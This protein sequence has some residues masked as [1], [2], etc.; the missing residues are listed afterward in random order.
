[1]FRLDLENLNKAL[2]HKICLR[3]RSDVKHAIAAPHQLS[4]LTHLL[5]KLAII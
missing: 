3:H 5:L 4:L 2:I 1:M